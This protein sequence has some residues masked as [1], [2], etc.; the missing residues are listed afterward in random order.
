MFLAVISQPSQIYSCWMSV[1][2]YKRDRAGECGMQD[3][4]G[5]SFVLR[6]NCFEDWWNWI[7]SNEGRL[8]CQLQRMLLML[9]NSYGETW[10]PRWPYYFFCFSKVCAPERAVE[11]LF[12]CVHLFCTK[13][14]AIQK[15]LTALELWRVKDWYLYVHRGSRASR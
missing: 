11:H 3:E 14:P 7:S 4:Q 13:P 8:C 5:G 1:H 12:F 9:K 6:Q 15:L 10:I 2:V